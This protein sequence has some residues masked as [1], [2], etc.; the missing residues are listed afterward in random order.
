[1]KYH[2]TIKTRG[3][4]FNGQDETFEALLVGSPEAIAESV[5]QSVL[6]SLKQGGTREITILPIHPASVYDLENSP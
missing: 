2:C 3:R 4:G 1:M 6:G 5:R